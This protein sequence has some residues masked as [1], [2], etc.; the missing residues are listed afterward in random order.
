MVYSLLGGPGGLWIRARA[1]GVWRRLEVAAL[2]SRKAA[3]LG[4]V[5]GVDGDSV[6]R[7][8]DQQR[9]AQLQGAIGDQNSRQGIGCATRGSKERSA[10]RVGSPEEYHVVGADIPSDSVLRR[11]RL[12]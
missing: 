11:P 12:E 1:E 2:S 4:C 7:G 6:T 9:G 8:G 3:L 10:G 5:R